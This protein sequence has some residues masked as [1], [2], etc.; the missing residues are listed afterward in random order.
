MAAA[1]EGTRRAYSVGNLT[2]YVQPLVLA[3][4]AST[5][6][7]GL[8]SIVGFWANATSEASVSLKAGVGV[9]E[10]SGTFTVNSP[11]VNFGKSLD[12][13]ILTTEL[14]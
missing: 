8:D 9:S 11:D 3:Q 14:E 13:Y 2:L 10:S 6:A 12:L 1:I 5:H 4:N 7:S